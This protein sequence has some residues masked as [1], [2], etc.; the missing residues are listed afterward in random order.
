MGGREP[1]AAGKPGDGADLSCLLARMVERYRQALSSVGSAQPR[2]ERGR[3]VSEISVT[4][5]EELL[6]LLLE[7]H[8]LTTFLQRL[9]EVAARDLSGPA[10]QVHCS[11]TVAR[12]RRRD[13]IANS[14]EAAARMDEIQYSCGEGPC[15]D[16]VVTGQ[17][18]DV[19]DLLNDPRYPRYRKAMADTGI[20]SIFAAPIPLPSASR[21][22]AA[23]NCYS[24]E[25]GFPPSLQARAEELASL[26]AR[27]VV[28][29]VRFANEMDRATDLAA[30]MES[31]TA[32]DLAAGVIMAQSGCSQEKAIH[33]LKTASMNRN[34]K[35]RDVATSIL[36]RFDDTD[37]TT[38]FS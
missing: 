7:S 5:T 24:S 14:D 23:L 18:I 34:V 13:T 6:D 16:C 32:I 30:A 4:G 26:A 11:V 19:P 21:A 37:P 17:P 28:L 1:A 38:Y 33:V 3:E 31:R 2:T 36:A 10:D 29:A 35:L 25:P 20:R 22:S 9:A 15:Q 8:D 12:E 27:S